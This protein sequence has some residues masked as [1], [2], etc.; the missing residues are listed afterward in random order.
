MTGDMIV[1]YAISDARPPAIWMSEWSMID[2]ARAS[3][4]DIP[5]GFH[6]VTVEQYNDAVRAQQAAVA[7][8]ELNS[9]AGLLV[10]MQRKRDALIASGLTTE[11]AEILVPNPTI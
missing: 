3:G 9:N 10:D 1:K 2:D 4:G 8:T 7:R 5:P 11:Q 6:E